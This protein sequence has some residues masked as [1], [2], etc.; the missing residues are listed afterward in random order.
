MT[1]KVLP[2]AFAAQGSDSTGAD[3]IVVDY[4]V[5]ASSTSVRTI[6][7]VPPPSR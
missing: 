7:P 2:Q 4:I 5:R 6:T 1:V 3:E